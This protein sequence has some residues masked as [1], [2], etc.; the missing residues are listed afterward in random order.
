VSRIVL[1]HPEFG[2]ALLDTVSDRAAG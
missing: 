1:G 2:Y